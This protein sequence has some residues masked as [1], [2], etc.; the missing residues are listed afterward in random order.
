M[1]TDERFEKMEGQLARMRWFNYCLICIVLA[2]G[3]WFIWKTFG[4][5]KALARF[6]GKVIRANSF[7]VEDEN[8]K[9][10]ASLSVLKGGPALLLNDENGKLSALLEVI[11]EG[12][13]L[14]MHDENGKARVMLL[15]AK[16]GAGLSL[17]DE[18][19]MTRAGLHMG[20]DGPKLVLYDENGK[21]IWRAP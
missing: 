1:T 7:I 8:G 14:W 18:N 17:S 2:L 10:R 5:E 11:K 13:R 19:G 12:P 4:P 9:P 21:Q 16:E 15:L 20:K 3:V 6:S